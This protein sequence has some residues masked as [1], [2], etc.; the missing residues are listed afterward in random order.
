M[1]SCGCAKVS[2]LGPN[3]TFKQA[4]ANVMVSILGD[5]K[6]IKTLLLF[7]LKGS[8]NGFKS[9]FAVTMASGSHLVLIYN[10]VIGVYKWNH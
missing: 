8:S 10:N 4:G 3:H 5:Q 1:P 7:H 9:K 6:I 2:S